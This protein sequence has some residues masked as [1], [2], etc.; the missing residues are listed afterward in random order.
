[1][2]SK[3]GKVMKTNVIDGD[4][5]D[6]DLTGT[7]KVD[8]IDGMGGNDTISGGNQHDVINGGSGNDDIAGNNGK[9]VANGGFGNDDIEGQNGKDKLD[10]GEGSNNVSGGNGKDD[11]TAGT[12]S[13]DNLEVTSTGNNVNGGNGKDVI[14]SSAS[15][16]QPE[17]DGGIDTDEDGTGNDPQMGTSCPIDDVLTG[18]RAPDTFVFGES[19]GNDVITD[20]WKDEIDLSALGLTGFADLVFSTDANGDAV[21]DTG[22]GTITL[23]DV[24]V[25][26]LT[27]KYFI[28]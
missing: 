12:T 13:I 24:D 4:A 15:L 17:T 1:M 21:I 26:D 3:W 22:E 18:G 10:G 16:C 2:Y 20:F 19:H 11:L 23:L 25:A 6:N 28:F 14:Y 5:G 9:D 8:I 27:D 7:N